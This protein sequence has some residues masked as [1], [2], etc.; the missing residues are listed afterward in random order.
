MSQNTLLIMCQLL[1]VSA[2]RCHHH[3]H[4]HHHHHQGVG[5]RTVVAEKLPEDGT[6]VVCFILFQLVHFVG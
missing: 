6:F 2:P 5:L 3:H 4:H 1:N